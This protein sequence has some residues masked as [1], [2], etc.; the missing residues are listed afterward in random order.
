MNPSPPFLTHL[1]LMKKHYLIHFFLF[2]SLALSLQSEARYTQ[3]EIISLNTSECS[4]AFHCVRVTNAYSAMRGRC[5]VAIGYRRCSYFARFLSFV[6]LCLF[7]LGLLSFVL[8]VVFISFVCSCFCCNVY[9]TIRC[10]VMFFEVLLSSV[11]PLF[12]L[13]LVVVLHFV[14]FYYGLL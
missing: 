9:L 11:L 14:T 8:F 6:C 1:S 4:A 2:I 12:L 10:V 3:M 5:C 7:I 13:F